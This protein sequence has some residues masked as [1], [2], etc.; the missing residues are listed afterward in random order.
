MRQVTA[1][2]ASVATESTLQS[3]NYGKIKLLH[4]AAKQAPY[5]PEQRSKDWY[6]LSA[7]LKRV[8]LGFPQQRSTPLP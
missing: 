2:S 5:E 4:G 1:V 3:F 7:V 6:C 8:V